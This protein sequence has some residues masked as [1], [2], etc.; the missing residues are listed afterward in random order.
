MW[1][2]QQSTGALTGPSGS[3][4]AT[5]YAGQGAGKNQPGWQSVSN[6]GPLP[7]GDYVIGLYHVDPHLGPCCELT[8]A[9]GTRMRGR[10][11]FY[12]HLPNPRWPDDSSD[13]CIIV[14]YASALTTIGASPDKALRV[15]A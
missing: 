4:V 15:V 9:V 7:Q 5:C 10:S 1:T 3:L 11:A 12:F 2:Y 14:P 8:P 13:G 6:T